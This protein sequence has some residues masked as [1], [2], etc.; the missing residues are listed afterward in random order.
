MKI[1]SL[2]LSVIL[3]ASFAVRAQVPFNVPTTDLEA[4]WSFNGNGNDLS[5]NTNNF[6]N[7]GAS[8]TTDRQGNLNAA[9]DFDG[10]DD[11]LIVNS[12]SFSFG[13]TDSFSVS[14]WTYKTISEYG[15]A[16]MQSSGASGNFIWI[17]QSGTSGQ[18]NYGINKQGSAW[19][20]ANS[21][22]GVNQWEHIVGTYANGTLRIYKNG[23]FVSSATYSNTGAAKVAL[24]F[25]V[26][27]SHG[28]NYYDGKIDDI[29]IW[30][31]VLSQN[32]IDGLFNDCNAAVARNPS[33][34]RTSVG[35]NAEFSSEATNP[36]MDFQWQNNSSGSF[37][38][39]SNSALYQGATSDTLKITNVT[40]SL[41]GVLYRCVISDSTICSVT[42]GGASLTVCGV[43]SS[44]PVDQTG[45]EN[46]QTKF[47]V[48]VSDS[49][50]SVQWQVN[51]SNGFV[52]LSNGTIYSGVN[53]DTLIL[54]NTPLSFSGSEYRCYMVSGSCMDT[55]STALLSVN[56][57]IGI[58]EYSTAIELYPNPANEELNF[59]ANTSLIGQSLKIINC[60]GTIVYEG[61]VEKIENTISISKLN[62]GN[63]F[64][65]VGVEKGISFSV[66]R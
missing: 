26:G 59:K 47:G 56:P 66:I 48:V 40:Q 29:G 39:I 34:A 30:S 42:S 11:Y 38:D 12:P 10:V 5:S 14:F 50:A 24:P 23:V 43:I 19:T 25:R 51:S 63:Y 2:I 16:L 60:A 41:D 15:I 4:W 49:N 45:I 44:D 52:D 28:G 21:T 18:L 55:S 46:A 57:N 3:T 62:A 36:G 20:W 31:R 8:L 17:F 9:Y 7:N 58:S 61:A 1:A 65:I 54:N 35:L 13:Q 22:Y 6:I 33:N 64:L 37:Q 32:E 27:R 53:T